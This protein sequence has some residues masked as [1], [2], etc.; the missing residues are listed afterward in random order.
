MAACCACTSAVACSARA[1]NRRYQEQSCE[2]LHGRSPI[3]C[4]T[5]VGLCSAA[6]GGVQS[7]HHFV[8][9]S[10]SVPGGLPPPLVR[11]CPVR[12]D[13]AITTAN[14]MGITLCQRIWMQVT[15]ILPEREMREHAMRGTEIFLVVLG[16]CD[17]V[18]YS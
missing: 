13:R 10:W 18:Q 16:S 7:A 11:L 8:L 9:P 4:W 14:H 2:I 17:A 5:S 6:T 15:F 3:G 1:A 12:H